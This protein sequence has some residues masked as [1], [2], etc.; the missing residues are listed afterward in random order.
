MLDD[1]PVIKGLMKYIKEGVISFYMPGH[2]NNRRGFEELNWI[3]NNL[4]KI[5]NTEVRG[6]DNLHIPEGMILDAQ[7][8]AAR[9][10][11]SSRSYF[12]VNGSTSGIYGMILGVTRPGDKIIIQRN[13]HKSVFTACLLG[14]L[15]A[16]Y[17]NPCILEGFNIAVSVGVDDV[18]KIMDENSD[19]KAVVLTY[20]TYYGTCMDLERIIYEAHKRNIMVFVDEAHGAHSY[21]SS[22]L[23]KG[24]ME[25]GADAAVTS[26]H[27]TTPALTQTALLNTGNIRT[28]GI[29]F[30]LRAFQSTSPSY[31]FMASMDAARHIMEERGSKLIDELLENINVFREKMGKLSFYEVL[32]AEHMEKGNIFAM[33]PT[34]IV[35]KSPIGGIRLDKILR[36]KY[37]LQV[38][39]SD[40]NNILALTSIGN[41]GESFERLYSALQEISAEYGE[42]NGLEAADNSKLMSGYIERG[43]LS[44][45]KAALSMRSAYYSPKRKVK[46]KSAAGMV[47][48]EMASPY[49]PGIPVLLPGEIITPEIIEEIYFYKNNG[50][51]INGLSDKSSEYI[52]VTF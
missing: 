10:F 45:G 48:S 2:K 9:A 12:L 42:F 13:C 20:P 25:C 35:I 14:D 24:A 32:G 38:E 33:D 15:E 4:Y 46:L 44:T 43:S 8:A 3:Q 47:S 23:P 28:E 37:G 49:P 27:K 11:K 19:A 40:I 6:L 31:V 36:E 7:R 26:L 34:K 30:M 51:H 16:V 50:I 29:E 21:F 1:M 52:Y 39:M 18:I 17:I 41:D 5:D 22:R